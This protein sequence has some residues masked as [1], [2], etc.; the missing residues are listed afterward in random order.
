MVTELQ[1]DKVISYLW[2]KAIEQSAGIDSLILAKYIKL[3]AEMLA[4]EDSSL[5]KT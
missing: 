4:E 3:R 5:R 2:D 1:E